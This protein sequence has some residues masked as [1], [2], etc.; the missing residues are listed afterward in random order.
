MI[1]LLKIFVLKSEKGSKLYLS[2]ND[3]H[4]NNY[5]NAT[6]PTLQLFKANHLANF[7]L[8][9]IPLRQKCHVE[10]VT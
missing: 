4:S 9:L 8:K 5:K 2:N 6:L 3:D 10:T 7:W 1:R